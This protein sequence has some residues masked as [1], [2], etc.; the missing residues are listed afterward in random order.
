M[1]LKIYHTLNL[2]LTGLVLSILVIVGVIFFNLDSLANYT[3]YLFGGLFVY[4]LVCYFGFKMFENN[5]DKRMI[6]KMVLNGDIALANIKSA[7]P[8]HLIRDSSFKNYHLWEIEIE[9]YDKQF[10]KH[11]DTIID[12]MNVMLKEIP[13]GSVYITYNENK[14]ERK[15]IIQNVMIGHVPT[16]QPIVAA[17]ENNK[18]IPIKYLNAYY[19]DGMI[20]ETYKQSLRAQKEGK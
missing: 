6:Q 18:N 10:K 14:P 9:F 3:W 8:I 13:N 19:R 17:Y 7:K 4:S 16:L 5:Y 12:K 2:I 11:T 1:Q 20:V 15:F